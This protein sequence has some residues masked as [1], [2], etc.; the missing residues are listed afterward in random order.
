MAGRHAQSSNR[1]PVEDAK[2]LLLP[3][4]TMGDGIWDWNLETGA[5]FCSDRWIE[6]LGYHREE[7]TPDLAFVAATIHPEDREVL[8]EIG[9]AHLDGKT[10]YFEC[11]YRMRMKSGEYRW[12]LGRGRVLARDP[13]GKALRVLGL[14]FDITERKATERALEQAEEQSRTIIETAGC[15]ILCIDTRY[16][17]LEWNR[18]AEKIYGWAR[19]EILGKNYVEW[20]LPEE[21]RPL[22]VE[23]I[24]RVFDG[25]ETEDYENPIITRDGSERVLL[26]NCRRLV[27][28]DGVTRGLVGVA[29]DITDLKRAERLREIAYQEMQVM[30]DRFDALRG[31]A[32]VCSECKKIRDQEGSWSNLDE[33]LQASMH[34]EMTHGL[35][36]ACTIRARAFEP[37]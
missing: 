27:D 34:V 18:G 8:G 26:W 3:L 2:R 13:R 36:P 29:Q 28:S 25:T 4:D 35:C 10:D 33:Y 1:R 31:L 22:V 12:T 32:R 37:T 7:V 21:V 30:L 23:E 16:R 24:Q 9:N 14:N 11:E 15:A 6:S 19:A 5:V 17:I 20:F